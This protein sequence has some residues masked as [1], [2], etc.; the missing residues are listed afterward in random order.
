MHIIPDQLQE[1]KQILFEGQFREFSN[2]HKCN[3]CIIPIDKPEAIFTIICALQGSD[4]LLVPPN[5]SIMD[6]RKILMKVLS[7]T[8]L[9]PD[10]RITQVKEDLPKK[11]QTKPGL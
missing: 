4:N 3:F 5:W 1:T 2:N 9:R 6:G 7:S 8:E 10:V 11:S